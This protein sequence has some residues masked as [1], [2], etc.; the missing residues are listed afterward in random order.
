MKRLLTAAVA[1]PL[2]LAAIFSLETTWF[3]AVCAL[4]LGWAAFE[5]V[6]MTRVWAPQA[7]LWLLPVAAVAMGALLGLPSVPVEWRVLAAPAI[8]AVVVVGFGSWVLLQRTPISQAPAALGALAYGTPYFGL[9]IASLCQI[10]HRDPWLVGL[11]VA[12]V[13]LGDTAAYYVG[14]AWGRHRLAP[15]VSPKKSW[16]GAIAGLLMSLLA[17]MAWC[18]YHL[19]HQAPSLLVLG[20]VTAVAAQLGDLVESIFKRASGLK[21]SGRILP[22]HG[23]ALDRADALLFAAPVFWLGYLW[24]ES[25]ALS[26]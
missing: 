7:P 25:A 2:A 17:T 6:V 3:F 9:P 24:L 26:P 11:L 4:T 20:L 14:S 8:A 19:G 15:V 16:E 21:D 23:G 10:H 22:G 1:L 18:Q 5:F 12:I 13:W